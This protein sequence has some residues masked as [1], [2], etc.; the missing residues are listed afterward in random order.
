MAR[1]GV[2]VGGDESCFVRSSEQE[3]PMP[4]EEI[5]ITSTITINTL[6]LERLEGAL[7]CAKFLRGEKVC[8]GTKQSAKR[9]L[10]GG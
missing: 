7:R 1:E 3:T 9:Y 5:T 8:V 6:S 10:R 2:R 4:Q